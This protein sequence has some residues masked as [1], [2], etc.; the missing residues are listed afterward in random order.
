[1]DDLTSAIP[2]LESLFSRA[3]SLRSPFSIAEHGRP[4]DFNAEK[5]MVASQLNSRLRGVKS[6]ASICR[7]HT[8]AID[9]TVERPNAEPRRAMLRVFLLPGLFLTIGRVRLG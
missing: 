3:R 6:R 4:I 7:P 8:A 9:R 5:T 1:M 2:A